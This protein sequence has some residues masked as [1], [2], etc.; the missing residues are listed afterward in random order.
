MAIIY[1]K[2]TN[3]VYNTEGYVCACKVV[4]IDEFNKCSMATSKHVCVD[5]RYHT[6]TTECLSCKNK[7]KWE[8]KEVQ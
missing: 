1:C 4:E 5:C 6:F 3:C 8:A 2:D 7:N